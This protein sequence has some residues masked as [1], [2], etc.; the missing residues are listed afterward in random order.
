VIVQLAA[1]AL[2]AD[3]PVAG[4]GVEAGLGEERFLVDEVVIFSTSSAIFRTETQFPERM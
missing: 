3:P 2:V 1:G 4:K